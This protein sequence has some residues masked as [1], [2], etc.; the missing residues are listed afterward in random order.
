MAEVTSAAYQDLRDYIQDNWKW[1]ELRDGE[2]AAILRVDPA[3]ER[4]EWSHEAQ[5]QVLELTITVKGE[6]ADITPPQAF[7][8][9]AIFK[10]AEGGNAFSV[11]TFTSFTIETNED[12]LTVKHQIE[13]P[14]VT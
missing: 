9:S 1:I 12:E 3:D 6:N 10:A 4:V 5:A 13:V 14:Q 2:D 7:A 8:S 11:E